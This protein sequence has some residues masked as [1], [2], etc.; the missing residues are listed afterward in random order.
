MRRRQPGLD[1]DLLIHEATF[2]DGMEEDAVLKRHS[3]VGD[4]IDVALPR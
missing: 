3:T 4:A 1:T 2:E